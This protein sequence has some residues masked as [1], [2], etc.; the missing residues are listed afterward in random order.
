MRGDGPDWEPGVAKSLQILKEQ[1]PRQVAL[2]AR[3][4]V[5]K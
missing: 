3:S 4:S 1:L 5:S 2:F